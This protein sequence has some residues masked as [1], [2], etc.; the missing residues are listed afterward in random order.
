MCDGLPC[1]DAQVG[2]KH[3]ILG[4]DTGNPTSIIDLKA[5]KTLGL[6]IEPILGDDGKPMAQYQK[7]TGTNIA[8]G[9]I[10]FK[11][12]RFLAVDLSASLK[13]GTLPHIDGTLAYGAFKDRI[14]QL[15]Y[16]AG[17]L[18]LSQPLTASTKCPGTCG[19]ISLI[20]FGQ[21]GPP[22]VTDRKSVV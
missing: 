13:D 3:L 10:E 14:V 7:A 12:L 6:T 16:P 9:D 8:I 15:D 11:E 22:I 17:V 2:G 20:T 5:A 19:D 4:I 18:N 21:H 1:V